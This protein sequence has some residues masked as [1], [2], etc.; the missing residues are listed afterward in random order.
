MEKFDPQKLADSE[1]ERI[2]LRVAHRTKEELATIAQNENI[3]LNALI[4]RCIEFSLNNTKK[5]IKIRKRR[6]TKDAKRSKN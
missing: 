3:S 6:R 4:I 1:L 2:T 5:D